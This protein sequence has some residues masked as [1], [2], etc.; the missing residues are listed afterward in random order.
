MKYYLRLKDKAPY[1]CVLG[2][3]CYAQNR[4]TGTVTIKHI[5]IFLSRIWASY[6]SNKRR[7]KT[8]CF[9]DLLCHV[10]SHEHIHAAIHKIGEH[11]ASRKFDNIAGDMSK[12]SVFKTWSGM[13]L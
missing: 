4:H 3:L 6:N 9:D 7:G 5:T 13:K 1:K 8:H 2:W 12:I 10:I 11:D